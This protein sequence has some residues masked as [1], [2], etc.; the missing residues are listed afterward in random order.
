[1]AEGK[2]HFGS[3]SLFCIDRHRSWYLVYPDQP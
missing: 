3:L 2:A 1:M